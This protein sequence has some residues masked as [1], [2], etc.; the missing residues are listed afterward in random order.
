[1]IDTQPLRDFVSWWQQYCKGDEKG[2]A[3]IFL[4]RLFKAFGHD[5]VPEAGGVF[6]ERI[7]RQRQGKKTTAFADL[8]VPGR[9]LIEMKKRGEDLKKH[10]AQAFEYWLYLVPNRPQGSGQCSDARCYS[11]VFRTRFLYDGGRVQGC[12]ARTDVCLLMLV[13]MICPPSALHPPYPIRKF[14]SRWRWRKVRASSIPL[15]RK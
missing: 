11:I 4:D 7:Q 15:G 8:V 5:G 2:E 6:E 14:Y 1:M 12:F 13:C 10:Y 3:Q 9:V